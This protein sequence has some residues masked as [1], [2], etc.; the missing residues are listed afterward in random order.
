MTDGPEHHASE[1]A[2]AAAAHHHDG[3]P[4][5]GGDEDV[6]RVTLDGAAVH[7]E[8]RVPGA[9]QADRSVDALL[10]LRYEDAAG[11]FLLHLRG[12][13]LDQRLQLTS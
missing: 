8:S 2:V 4:E 13:R 12:L 3:D 7:L 9:Q 5:R 11:R 6:D 10:L 1:A